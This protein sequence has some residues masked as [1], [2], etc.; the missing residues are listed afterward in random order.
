MMTELDVLNGLRELAVVFKPPN[1]TSDLVRLAGVYRRALDHMDEA[2]FNGAIAG[3]IKTGRYWPRPTQLLEA[4]DQHRRDNPLP[5][6]SLP[7]R[8]RYLRWQSQGDWVS[9]PCPVCDARA[10][11]VDDM[12]HATRPQV[13]HDHQIHYE[14]GIGYA[15]PRTGPVGHDKQLLAVGSVSTTKAIA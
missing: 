3:Y 7:L 1:D 10:E 2:E 12:G 11:F 14:A 15:G 9:E 13:Y 6:S 4:A 5:S 8:E